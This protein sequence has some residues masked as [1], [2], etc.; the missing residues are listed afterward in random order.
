MGSLLGVINKLIPFIE[1]HLK[2]IIL[3][4][5]DTLFAVDMFVS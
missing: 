3:I 5:L 1:S 4:N 2:R